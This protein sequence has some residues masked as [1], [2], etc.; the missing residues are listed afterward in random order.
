MDSSNRTFVSSVLFL[1]IVE[2]SKCSVTEQMKLKQRFNVLLVRALQHVAVSERIVLDTGDGAA[3]SFLGNPEDALFAALGL[4]DGVAEESVKESP[5]LSVR[6]GINLGPIRL[7]KDI[8]GQL[9]IIG[10]GINVAQRIMSFAEPGIVLVSRSYYEVVSRLSD[11]YAQIF[12]DAGI[13]TDKH[14]REHTVYSI[15][16]T[17]STIPPLR[18]RAANDKLDQLFLNRPERRDAKSS[19]TEAAKGTLR[20]RILIGVCTVAALLVVSASAWRLTRPTSTESSALPQ[21]QPVT[22]NSSAKDRQESA[23]PVA[24]SKPAPTPPAKAELNLVILPWG[25]VYVDGKKKGVSPPL[26]T[27]TLAPGKHT[28][29]IRNSAFPAHIE[30]I[31]VKAGVSTTVRHKF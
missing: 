18:A 7:I 13:R 1:D 30:T 6:L 11:D 12:R 5:R 27:V 23:K 15:G 10:D 22:K 19:E 3:I 24:Q 14:V 9:N 28:I 26:K 8:N 21:T 29:E 16:D 31:D 4:R 20:K 17:S 25:E 2:Y